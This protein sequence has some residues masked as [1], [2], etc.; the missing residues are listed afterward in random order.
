MTIE[1]E[2]LRRFAVQVPA[3]AVGEASPAGIVRHSP[4]ADSLGALHRILEDFARASRQPRERR[5]T[6]VGHAEARLSDWVRS[7]IPSAT[8]RR[9]PRLAPE[10][11]HRIEEWIDAHLH[12]PL[13]LSRLCERAGVQA[14]CLQM[15]F[16][17][18]RQQSPMAFVTERRLV[19]AHAALMR[20]EHESVTALASAFG[21]EHPGRFA[22]GYRRLFGLVPSEMRRRSNARR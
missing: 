1:A 19:A 2:S 3:A 22:A 7:H 21:F 14:R 13:S 9:T 16:E 6:A 4:P 20:G 11:V 12:E 18:Q 8:G 10:R 15:A 17:S 5:S